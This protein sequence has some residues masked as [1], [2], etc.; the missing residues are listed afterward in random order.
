MGFLVERPSPVY[1]LRARDDVV[2]AD[3][4]DLRANPWNCRVLSFALTAV[5]CVGM[6][7]S[8]FRAI[9]QVCTFQSPAGTVRHRRS[10]YGAARSHERHRPIRSNAASPNPGKN[11]RG[12][13]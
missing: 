2:A 4:A 1:P 5:I 6:T 7:E 11:A 9:D 3:R 12:R 13:A 8:Q 10:A